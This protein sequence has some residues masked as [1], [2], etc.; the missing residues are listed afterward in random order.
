[1]EI[2]H[3]MRLAGAASWRP[4]ALPNTAAAGQAAGGARVPDFGARNTHH[5]Y[6]FK[7]QERIDGVIAE[8]GLSHVAGSLV[9]GSASIRGISGG[10][11]RRVTIAMALGACCFYFSQVGCLNVDPMLGQATACWH[12]RMHTAAVPLAANGGASQSVWRWASA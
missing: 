2:V 1:M 11:R 10:E 4:G 7:S 9:G 6:H 8:L 3:A 12:G 5:Q